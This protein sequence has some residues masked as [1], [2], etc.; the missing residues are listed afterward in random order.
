MNVIAGEPICKSPLNTSYSK[1]MF[2]FSKDKRFKE[3]MPR[4]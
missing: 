4:R 2:S 3:A 1:Q